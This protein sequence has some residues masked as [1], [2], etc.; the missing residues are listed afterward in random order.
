MEREQE[1][2][3]IGKIV[4]AVSSSEPEL[5]WPLELVEPPKT[6]PAALTRLYD[7]HF[8]SPLTAPC[9]HG[10][11]TADSAGYLGDRVVPCPRLSVVDS[12][13]LSRNAPRQDSSSNFIPHLR[14]RPDPPSRAFAS[15]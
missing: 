11:T 12:I 8:H 7:P 4:W 14:S 1:I 3:G 6:K 15:G 2:L 13:S 5:V 10:D 9:R